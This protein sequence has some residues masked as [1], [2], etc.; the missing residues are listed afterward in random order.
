MMVDSSRIHGAGS[1][2]LAAD[3]DIDGLPVLILLV[4][5]DAPRRWA[6]R[7]SS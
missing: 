2:C 1:S 6:A 4:Q 5:L 7:Y 3:G